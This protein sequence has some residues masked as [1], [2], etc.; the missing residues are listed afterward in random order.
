MRAKVYFNLH[1]S[2]WS[3]KDCET[4]LV[5]GHADKVC[6]INVV[7]QVSQ[8]GRNRVLIEKQKNVHAYLVGDVNLVENFKS[9]RG[10]LVDATHGEYPALPTNP[11][12]T[13]I[14]YNPYK[15][16]NFVVADTEEP[17]VKVGMVDMVA[18]RKCIGWGVETV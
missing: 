7:P 4:G 3:I 16:T 14:T 15:Y 13:V 1:T 5:M 12:G 2:T 11:S 8:A 9:Y 10:R 17:I 6:L 18:D